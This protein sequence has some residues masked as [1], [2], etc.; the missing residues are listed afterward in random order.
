MTEHNEP[1]NIPIDGTEVSF[2]KRPASPI[3][4]QLRTEFDTA[5]TIVDRSGALDQLDEVLLTRHPTSGKVIGRPRSITTRAFLVVAVVN[6]L[7]DGSGEVS[8][9]VRTFNQLPQDLLTA[10]G[11][12]FSAGTV[13]EHA[14]DHVWNRISEACNG[15]PIRDGKRIP[16]D[17]EGNRFNAFKAQQ[18]DR[19]ALRDDLGEDERTSVTDRR[20]STRGMPRDLNEAELKE[21]TRRLESVTDALLQATIPTELNLGLWAIDWTDHEAWARTY[22]NA[23]EDK[24]GVASADPDAGW[25]RR[26][27]KGNKISGHAP[28]SNDDDLAGDHRFELSKVERYYGYIAH[29]AVTTADT[30]PD[31]TAPEIAASMR[32][33]AAHDMDGVAPALIDMVD[34]MQHAGL[35]VERVIVDRGYSMR[36]A[37]RWLVPLSDRGVFASFDLPHYQFGRRGTHHGAVI[38]N[39]EMYCPH[40]PDE[41]VNVQIPGSSSPPSVWKDYHAAKASL[42]Q[43]KFRRRG[44][45]TPS[46][47]MRV[48]CPARAGTCRCPLVPSSQ[49]IPYEKDIPTIEDPPTEDEAPK[50]CTAATLTVPREVGL[51]VRQLYPHGTKEW[52]AEYDQRTSVER[53]NSSLK[54][55]QRV[56]HSQIRVLGQAKNTLM[57]CFAAVATNVR[58]IRN[59]ENATGRSA[60]TLTADVVGEAA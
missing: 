4:R 49:S 12:R 34:S 6:F 56:Q 51:G 43:Y 19:K 20:L 13:P 9:I 39:G 38:M 3:E 5:I 32:V 60:S 52:I 58:H 17:L 31:G 54:F 40:M 8:S 23:K 2:P 25:G 42:D 46:L 28:R 18:K 41:L 37:E 35:P 33:A 21:R 15:S 7:L 36:T 30:W 24:L 11:V 48:D 50:C 53:F 44:K 29:F 27:P 57:L 14:I 22:R 10:L 26:H 16:V 59:W 1:T 45:L 55:E 47:K